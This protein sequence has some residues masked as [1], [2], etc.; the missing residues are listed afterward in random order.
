MSDAVDIGQT[1]NHQFKAIEA[2]VSLHH[3][4][5]RDFGIAVRFAGSAMKTLC[6][7]LGALDAPVVNPHRADLHEPFHAREPHRLRYVDRAH[8]VDLHSGINRLRHFAADQSG[9]MDD[10]VDFVFLDCFHQRRKIA[11]VSLHDRHVRRSQLVRQ[12]IFP[13]RYVV[14]ND[15]LPAFK[16]ELRVRGAD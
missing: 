15:V 12:K 11:H 10:F 13:R 1:N 6:D 3:Q 16:P 2:L 4:F 7:G 14:E 8:H 5:F 9:G